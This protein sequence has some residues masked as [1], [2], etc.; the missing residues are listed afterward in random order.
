VCIRSL[1]LPVSRAMV[2]TGMGPEP[3]FDPEPQETYQRLEPA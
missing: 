2:P 1:L 3:R